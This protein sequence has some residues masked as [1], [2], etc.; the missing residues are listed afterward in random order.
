MEDCLYLDYINYEKGTIVLKEQEYPLI[1]RYFPTINPLDPDVLSPEERVL[2][3]KL[4]LSFV[5]SKKMQQHVRFLY[6]K[7][8]IYLT[9][10]GNLLYHGCIAMN[11]DGSFKSFDIGGGEQYNGKAFLDRVDRLARQGF[12]AKENNEQK[13]YGMDAMWYL[14]CGAQSPL[15]GKER[16]TTFQRYFIADPSTHIEKRNPYYTYRDQE[17]IVCQILKEFNL[18][19][20]RGRIINGHVPVKVKKGERPTK[21]NGKLIVIDGG[22]SKTYQEQTGIAGYTLISNSRGLLLAAHHP[23]ESMQKAVSEEIDINSETEI[24]ENHPVR[25]RVKDTDHGWAIQQ[26]IKELQA[27]LGAYREGMIKEQ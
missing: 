21:A 20:D 10:D 16:M 1:D 4:K 19:P 13:L 2:M 7:G 12:F 5:N 6:S 8:S 23:F 11:E 24:L 27:L 15:F 14:W 3:D 17:E 18:D 22:F 26:H 25:M 9:H